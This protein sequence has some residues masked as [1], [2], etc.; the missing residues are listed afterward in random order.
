MTVYLLTASDA[1]GLSRV[2]VA[3]PEARL[4]TTTCV[5][6]EAPGEPCVVYVPKGIF[7]CTACG[8]G[9]TCAVMDAPAKAETGDNPFFT[10]DEEP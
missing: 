2:L 9:G 1:P 6:C 7:Y 8:G 5:W 10:L 3:P 4:L